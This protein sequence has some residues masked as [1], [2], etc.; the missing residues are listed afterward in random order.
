MRPPG[1]GETPRDGK[2]ERTTQMFYGQPAE[3]ADLGPTQLAWRRYGS[4]PPLLLVHGFP[5]SGFTWRRVLPSLAPHFTCYV[6]DLP[7]LGESEWTASTDFT[8]M[9]QARTL[10]AFADH[11]G[12]DRYRVMAQDTGGTFSRCLASIDGARVER[13]AVINTEMPGHRP[14]WIPLYQALLA[15]PG[16]PAAFRRLMRSQAFLLSAMGFGGCFTNPRLIGGDFHEHVIT[17]LIHSPRRLEGMRRYLREL[18]DW[19]VV[20]ALPRLHAG[21]SMPVQLIWGADD[22]TFPIRHAREMVRQL[23]HGSLVEIPGARLLVHEEK[24]EEV[25]RAAL[26]FFG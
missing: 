20:D 3:V 6:P 13:L 24:P 14:P 7:G 22:P 25:A 18:R 11:L 5:L 1:P 16:T 26:E 19:S 8:W 15:L 2:M 17:P 4:G 9:G 21:L 10:Q 23:P 12:L